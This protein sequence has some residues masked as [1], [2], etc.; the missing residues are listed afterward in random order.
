MYKHAQGYFKVNGENIEMDKFYVLSLVNL[1]KPYL[2]RFSCKTRELAN[3][4]IILKTGA[5]FYE[6]IKGEEALERGIPLSKKKITQDM[7]P[8]KYAY[9]KECNTWRKKK[10]YRNNFRAF[11]RKSLNSANCL[12]QFTISYRSK[13]YGLFAYTTL[14]AF[15][16]LTESSGMTWKHFIKNVD[17]K[18]QQIPKETLYIRNP[19]INIPMIN[20]FYER[21]FGKKHPKLKY[22]SSIGTMAKFES[23]LLSIERKK[24][25]SLLF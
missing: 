21:H 6:V 24:P 19:G 20:Q 7:F 18:P 14:K 9:P 22:P 16:L 25:K 11:L 15:N 17:S 10:R 13:Q 12:K 23:T 1:R 3:R 4:Y 2:L 8:E 5:I